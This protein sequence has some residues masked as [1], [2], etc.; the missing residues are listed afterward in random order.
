MYECTPGNGAFIGGDGTACFGIVEVEV[1]IA[2]LDG[3]AG[4]EY[5]VT[6]KEATAIENFR[7]A[8]TF[9]VILSVVDNF[10]ASGIPADCLCS[11]LSDQSAEAAITQDGG[12]V[13]LSGD[14]FPDG[15]LIGEELLP[16]NISF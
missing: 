13:P 7:A 10:G 15:V 1:N 12:F 4:F 14:L 3:A 16:I 6:D 8:H 2:G 11:C 9:V 5:E